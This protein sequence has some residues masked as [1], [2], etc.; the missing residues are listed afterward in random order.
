MVN[1]T[2][3]FHTTSFKTKNACV[4]L[5]VSMHST[6]STNIIIC[7]NRWQQQHS[8]ATWMNF[9]ETYY[10]INAGT[11]CILKMLN[12]KEPNTPSLILKSPCR[13]FSWGVSETW[14]SLSWGR[15]SYCWTVLVLSFI[16]LIFNIRTC[17]A[18]AILVFPLYEI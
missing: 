3:T 17:F 18:V 9:P 14:R 5:A 8:Q 16:F 7:K 6:F 11:T 2:A 1:F 12:L 10:T 4:S 13:W 15:P